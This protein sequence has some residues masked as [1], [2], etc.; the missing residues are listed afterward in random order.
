MIGTGGSDVGKLMTMMGVT[1]GRSFKRSFYR[2]ATFVQKKILKRCRVIV[3]TALREEINLTIEDLYEDNMNEE[4]LSNIMEKITNGELETMNNQLQAIP[5][6][7][8]YD[9]G[10]QKRAGGRVYDSLSGH[11]F[12]IGCRSGKVIKF[13]VLKKMLHMSNI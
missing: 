12:L 7:V 9:M 5:L 11:G 13:G 10:W 8:S 2:S 1:G 4:E 6:A 3:N